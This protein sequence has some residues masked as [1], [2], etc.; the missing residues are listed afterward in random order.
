MTDAGEP[1]RFVD[2][3]AIS[4]IFALIGLGAA[5]GLLIVYGPEAWSDIQR[6]R[7][8]DEA[9]YGAYGGIASALFAGFVLMWWTTRMFISS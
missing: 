7:W 3:R 1:I 2:G 6:G 9:C 4:V 8:Q 5:V